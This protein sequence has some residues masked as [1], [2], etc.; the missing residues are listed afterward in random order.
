MLRSGWREVGDFLGGS[1][2][3]FWE[4]YPLE[5]QLGFWRA[6]GV[7]DVHVRRLSLGGGVVIWGA[8]E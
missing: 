3:T 6:A 2:R 5:R 4:R 8:R 1:I 7:R